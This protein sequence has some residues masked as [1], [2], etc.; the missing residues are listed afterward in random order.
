MEAEK[1]GALAAVENT[2]FAGTSSG[3]Y[4]LS[5]ETW[6]LLSVG[7]ADLHGEKPVI[8]ALAA[9]K[10]RLY[11]AAGKKVKRGGRCNIQVKN[12]RQRLVVTLPIH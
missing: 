1:V 2:V 9:S 5:A 7:P 4:R 6:E 11:V 3:L 8:H 10:H 12:N